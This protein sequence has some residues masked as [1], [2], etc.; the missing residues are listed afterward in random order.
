[1]DI[2]F[3]AEKISWGHFDAVH[4]ANYP[5]LRTNL[6]KVATESIFLNCCFAAT[7]CPN[8]QTNLQK[9]AT[10]NILGPKFVL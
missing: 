1:M 6:Q 10:E 8:A 9:G 4:C 5:S 7:N 2:I 3:A